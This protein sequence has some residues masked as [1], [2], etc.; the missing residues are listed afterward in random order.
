MKTRHLLPAGRLALVLAFSL[1]PSA[2][3][4]AVTTID[5][6]HPY[7]WGANLGW[8]NWRGDVAHGAVIGEYVCA[9]YVWAANVGWI[10]L[11]SGS[12]ANGIQY[13]NNSGS[14]Y[15]VN[16]DGLGNLRGY[17]WGANIG[18]INFEVNGAPR[19]DPVTGNFTGY[20]WSANCGWI[21]LSNAVAFV[22]TDTIVAGA[23]ADGDGITDAWERTWFGNLTTATAASDYD[24]DGMTDLQEYLAGTDPLDLND[25]LRIT[26]I[27]RGMPPHSPTYVRLEWASQPTRCYRLEQR[28]ALAPASPWEPHASGFENLLGWNNIGFDWL[29]QQQFYRIRAV[30]PLMP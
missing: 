21:S 9:G 6:A 14:D 11:G 4:Q 5:V 27:E 28:T 7:A 13:Q 17:A 1:P 8:M 30:R 12:P 15:G 16:R 19:V 25:N 23:D 22:Q 24:G 26:Y 29:D 10:S 2:L 3:L 20:A 18:W